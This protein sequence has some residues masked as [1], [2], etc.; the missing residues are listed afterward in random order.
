MENERKGSLF[1]DTFTGYA[2]EGY[3]ADL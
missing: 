2:G 1:D 3:T